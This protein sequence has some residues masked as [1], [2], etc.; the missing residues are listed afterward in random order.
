MTSG[1]RPLSPPHLVLQVLRNRLPIEQ[2]KMEALFG[3]EIGHGADWYVSARPALPKDILHPVLGRRVT[4]PA[5]AVLGRLN[6]LYVGD[7]HCFAINE[8]GRVV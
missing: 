8:H 6:A 3:E 2:H 1:L 5:G 4:I 7:G